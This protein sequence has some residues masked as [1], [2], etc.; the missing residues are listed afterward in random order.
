MMIRP[1]QA[2]ELIRPNPWRYS[3]ACICC[4]GACS[5]DVPETE[6]RNFEAVLDLLAAGRLTVSN[7]VTRTVGIGGG[8][9]GLPAD[10]AAQRAVSGHPPDLPGGGGR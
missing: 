1:G 8:R 4:G 5:M 2:D 6:E 10:R 3:S 7:L 9:R